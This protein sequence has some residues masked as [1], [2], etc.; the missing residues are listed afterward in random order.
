MDFPPEN[1][2]KCLS[3]PPFTLIPIINAFG[4][5]NTFLTVRK[6]W[7]KGGILPIAGM[8]NNLQHWMVKVSFKD[9]DATL[10]F[11]ITGF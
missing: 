6:T 1:T 4:R 3:A 9:I 8:E 7:W 2:R 10:T 11:N 5:K